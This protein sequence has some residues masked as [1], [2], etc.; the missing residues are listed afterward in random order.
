MSSLARNKMY[1]SR[2]A[3]SEQ[4]LTSESPARDG[5]VAEAA[6]PALP[7]LHANDAA[8]RTPTFEVTQ[9]YSDL[10]YPAPAFLLQAGRDKS[11]SSIASHHTCPAPPQSP[12]HLLPPG[13]F[14]SAGSTHRDSG[15]S[16]RSAQPTQYGTPR[17]SASLEPDSQLPYFDD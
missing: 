7:E 3:S 5:S 9:R 17:G 4:S 6:V 11:R 15:S 12:A 2:A 1:P 14:S 8:G 13:T 16:A 10:P